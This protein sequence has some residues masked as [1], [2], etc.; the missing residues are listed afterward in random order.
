[1][2]VL[3]SVVATE[4]REDSRHGD[5]ENTE[6]V[7]GLSRVFTDGV[8]STGSAAKPRVWHKERR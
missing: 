6:K 8:S 3:C 7:Q 5:A 1:M 2:L 4:A